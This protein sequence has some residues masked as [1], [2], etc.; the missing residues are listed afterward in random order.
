MD[1]K[2]QSTLE[3]FKKCQIKDVVMTETVTH[4][5]TLIN[6]KNKVLIKIL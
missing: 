6:Y 1:W 3:K 2:Y 4:K 5:N